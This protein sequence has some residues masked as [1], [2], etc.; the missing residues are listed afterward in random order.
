MNYG[1]Q[2]KTLSQ[3]EDQEVNRCFKHSMNSAETQSITQDTAAQPRK[4]TYFPGKYG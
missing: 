4:H 3:R 2:L 1:V